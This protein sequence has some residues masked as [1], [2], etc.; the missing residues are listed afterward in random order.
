MNTPSLQSI[1][2]YSRNISALTLANF[3][4]IPVARVEYA[5]KQHPLPGHKGRKPVVA[6]VEGERYGEAVKDAAY[7]SRQLLIAMLRT[8]QCDWKGD[9][10]RIARE[11]VL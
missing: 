2:G 11:N 4:Q 6:A 9:A 7:A 8:G 1:A 3:L 10:L 5:R